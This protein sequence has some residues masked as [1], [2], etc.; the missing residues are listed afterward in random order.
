MNDMHNNWASKG[1]NSTK[2]SGKALP[3]ITGHLCLRLSSFKEKKSL[4]LHCPIGFTV[5]EVMKKGK[6]YKSE[7]LFKLNIS[8][9][10]R[11]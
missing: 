9:M 5:F 2:S 3:F 6:K 4:L 1:K 8:N 7:D 11:S 10:I